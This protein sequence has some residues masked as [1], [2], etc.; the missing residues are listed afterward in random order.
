MRQ[1]S[2]A[3]ALLRAPL[4]NTDLFRDVGRNWGGIGLRYLT[5]LLAISWAVLVLQG[6]F[7]LR[8][9]QHNEFPQLVKDVPPITIK[10]GVVSSPVAQP[11]LIK[12][13]DTGR[14]FAILDTTGQIES[15]DDAGG[16]VILLTRDKL[17]FHQGTNGETRIRDLSGVKS[18]FVDRQRLAGW[19]DTFVLWF[20]PFGFAFVLVGSLAYRIVQG[21]IYAAI[22]LIF[23]S[24]FDARLTY[25]ALMRLAFVSITPVILLDTVA[26]AAGWVIPFWPL[27]CFVMAMVCLAIAVRANRVPPG[28]P[29]PPVYPAFAPAPRGYGNV[30]PYVPPTPPNV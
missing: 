26:W 24:V 9:F 14:P 20:L 17:H 5:Y 12:D 28:T 2:E 1:Y 22:G 3:G 29:P 16:A 10:D 4:P 13:P 25:A 27:A 18:F 8:S 23:N 6:W 7:G 11:Y 15:L 19:M 21:L 30:G